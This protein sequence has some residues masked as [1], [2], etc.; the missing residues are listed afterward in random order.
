MLHM[1]VRSSSFFSLL[2][3]GET[4]LGGIGKLVDGVIG[5]DENSSLS[6]NQSPCVIRIPF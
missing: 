4:I 1:M 2:L 3:I 6:W 5:N